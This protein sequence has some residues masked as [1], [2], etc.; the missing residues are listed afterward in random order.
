MA[1]FKLL[2]VK[3]REVNLALREIANVVN[4]LRGGKINPIGDVTLALS[5]TTTT[6]TDLYCS[7][8]SIVLL[9]PKDANA[10]AEAWYV[11]PGDQS[12]TITHASAGTTRAFR[13]VILG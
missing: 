11:T 10:A 2:P 3:F 13:Y 1:G 12:F 6:V 9:M 8:D 4:S 7:P 5:T